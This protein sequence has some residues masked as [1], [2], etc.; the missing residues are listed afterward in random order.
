M[1]DATLYSKY[2]SMQTKDVNFVL[3][4]YIKTIKWKSSES[5][6]DVGSGSGEVT[7]QLLAPVLPHDFEKL[8][9]LDISPEM[10]TYH[11]K[12]LPIR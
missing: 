10:T 1:D 8:V 2:H 7:M 4:N 9:G 12:I 6:L 3:E 5:I 11:P